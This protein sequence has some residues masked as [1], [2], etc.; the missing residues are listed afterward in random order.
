MPEKPRV[1]E[2][3]LTSWILELKYPT[4]LDDML[5]A[6]NCRPLIYLQFCAIPRNYSNSVLFHAKREQL[7]ALREQLRAIPQSPAQF[8]P[9]EFQ[10][11][12]YLLNSCSL[13]NG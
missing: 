9:S 7:R 6:H 12:G 11:K 4:Q 13:T 2:F 10:E 1:T 8:R 3:T 5:L